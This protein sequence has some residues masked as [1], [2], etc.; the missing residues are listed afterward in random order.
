MS[1]MGTPVARA[2]ICRAVHSASLLVRPCAGPLT[3]RMWTVQQPPSRVTSISKLDIGPL[4]ADRGAA[5][6]AGVS[7]LTTDAA[8][9]LEDEIG[10]AP[11]QMDRPG[12]LRWPRQPTAAIITAWR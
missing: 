7:P 6:G 1:S 10:H 3:S 9:T 11:V 5:A 4:L 2:I 8:F 12:A